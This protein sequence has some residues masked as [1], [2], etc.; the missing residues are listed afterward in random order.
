MNADGSNQVNLSNNQFGDY[1]PNWSGAMVNTPPA[2][3]ITSSANGASFTGPAITITASAS[4]SDGNVSRVDF[5]SGTGLIGTA[6]SAPYT[7]NWNNVGSGS[8][9]LTARPQTIEALPPPQIR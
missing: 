2:V 4:D 5:Y 3:S 8:Y 6:T 9:S 1:S 7:I